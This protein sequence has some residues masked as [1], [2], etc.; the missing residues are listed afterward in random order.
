MTATVFI[1]AQMKCALKAW[2]LHPRYSSYCLYRPPL[3]YHRLLIEQV[4]LPIALTSKSIRT[5]FY[6]G[7]WSKPLNMIDGKMN[8]KQ[9]CTMN[10]WN[11]LFFPHPP[12]FS[13]LTDC[14][15]TLTC[16]G[17]V[18]QILYID[19]YCDEHFGDSIF[20]VI[21]GRQFQQ[22][23]NVLPKRFRRRDQIYN[24]LS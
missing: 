6:N 8:I 15:I 14:G 3:I 24:M 2:Y 5:Q 23:D 16:F 11:G 4:N 12:T 21:D 10:H 19:D 1:D 18:L 20:K 22:L 7:N 13:R 17:N 9:T